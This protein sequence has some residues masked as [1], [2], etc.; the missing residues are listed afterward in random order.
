MGI[1]DLSGSD[2]NSHFAFDQQAPLSTHAAHSHLNELK[3]TS[4]D[5]LPQAREP[6]R[7]RYVEKS[8]EWDELSEANSEWETAEDEEEYENHF[9]VHGVM[10]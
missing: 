3:A 4:T 10:L 8:D 5:G 6:A 7:A 9:Q 1:L 2:P